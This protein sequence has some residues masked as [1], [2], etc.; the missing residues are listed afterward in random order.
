MIL[1]FADDFSGA[2]EVAG[3]AHRHGITAMVTSGSPISSGVEFVAVD[4][5][6]RSLSASEA[7]EKALAWGKIAAELA[8]RLLYKKTDSV[9]RGHLAEEL[10]AMLDATGRALGLLI[11]ANPARNRTISK[12]EYRI[13]GVPL[14][15]TEFARDP[16]FPICSSQVTDL[17]VG[18][19]SLPIGSPL[20]DSGLVIGDAVTERD[21]DQ[22]A[23][24]A[25]EGTL[26]AG[27]S[28]FLAAL[29]R[30]HGKHVVAQ[31]DP[32]DLFQRK[33]LLVCGSQS[34]NAR[35][36]AES[37]RETGAPVL[38]TTT[39]SIEDST[40]RLV[41]SLAQHP[42]TV[43]RHPREAN[44]SPEELTER[45]AAITSRALSLFS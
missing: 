12:G 21:L 10:C 17:V 13:K 22:W 28:P 2:S 31:A 33:I 40:K 20:P 26:P 15:E 24:S 18:A 4:M 42:I 23:E 27:A 32:N 25:N 7:G 45:I 38:T 9:L 36:A 29:L 1:A 39:D 8:P 3:V 5:G 11:P 41:E 37:L 43:L 19:E 30:S 14:A 6:T 44:D 16:A 34:D 35:H